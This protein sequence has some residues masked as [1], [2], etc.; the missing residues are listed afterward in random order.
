MG[1]SISNYAICWNNLLYQYIISTTYINDLNIIIISIFVFILVNYSIISKNDIIRILSASNQRSSYYDNINNFDLNYLYDYNNSYFNSYFICHNKFQFTNNY[2][3]SYNIDT[4]QYNYFSNYYFTYHKH[5]FY[6]IPINIHK[7]FSVGTSETTSI[8]MNKKINSFF[9][10]D[11]EFDQWLAGVIDASGKIGLTKK[12]NVYIEI[13]TFIEDLKMLRFIQ[14][15]IGGNIKFLTDQNMVQYRIQK[16][17]GIINI[18]NRIKNFL[19]NHERIEQFQLIIPKFGIQ[20]DKNIPITKDSKWFAGYFDAKG[21]VISNIDNRANKDLSIQIISDNFS[22]VNLFSKIFGGKIQEI[23]SSNY[24]WYTISKDQNINFYNY[25]I[26]NIRQFQTKKSMRLYLI[27]EYYKLKS[28]NAHYKNSY[29][30]STWENF[31]LKWKV[32]YNSIIDKY[33]F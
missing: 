13:V 23:Q 22:D 1:S 3:Y 26:K 33:Y 17:S 5:N 7:D 29:L 6:Y 8:A 19:C 32:Y 11:I 27:S 24:K 10:E 12:N 14:N 28:Q 2:Y 20:R 4:I 25:F 31:N 30:S 16:E 18:S 9:Y 15:Y 21:Y